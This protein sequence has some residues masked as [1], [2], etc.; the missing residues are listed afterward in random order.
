VP[1]AID[2]T[3]IWEAAH[4]A[5]VTT[6]EPEKAAYLLETIGPRIAAAALGMS[7]ARPVKAWARGSDTG[8]PREA[9]VTKRLEVLYRITRAISDAYTPGVAS[10]FLRSANPQ[11]DDNA[12]LLALAEAKSDKDLREVLVATRALL[13][14]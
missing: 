6:P 10:R 2:F 4:K 12:P 13:E 1:T 9:M 11:L 7:D 3:G 14:G 5:S 8:G